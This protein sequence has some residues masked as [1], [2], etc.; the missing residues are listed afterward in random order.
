MKLLI[1]IDEDL[2]EM[3]RDSLGDADIIEDII[4][5]GTPLPNHKCRE[6]DNF[7][8]GRDGKNGAI[9]GRCS[10]IYNW[11]DRCGRR[12]GAHIACKKFKER[13]T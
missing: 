13:E 5:N 10:V 6:C 9:R 2:Y 8:R 3:C 12:Y 11:L 4:A 1:N 7:T